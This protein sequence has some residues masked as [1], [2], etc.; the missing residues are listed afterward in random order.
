MPDREQNRTEQRIWSWTKLIRK[1]FE[2]AGSSSAIVTD[3]GFLTLCFVFYKIVLCIL[4]FIDFGRNSQ[5]ALFF[6]FVFY[7][8]AF[9]TLLTLI[10]IVKFHCPG[11]RGARGV[12]SKHLLYSQLFSNWL[13]SQGKP[14]RFYRLCKIDH[15]LLN[16]S[17]FVD[18]LLIFCLF[19]R[20]IFLHEQVRPNYGGIPVTVGVTLYILSIGDLSEKV[21]FWSSIF[22][23]W[24]RI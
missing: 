22:F 15:L 6:Y 2:Y 4:Y 21:G 11:G 12:R 13:R 9:Y 3:F 19:I 14:S 20:F 5:G 17:S 7:K 16:W 24:I 8:I 23:I 10:K 1:L 18:K